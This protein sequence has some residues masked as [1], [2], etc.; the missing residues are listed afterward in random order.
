MLYYAIYRYIC[1]LYTVGTKYCHAKLKDSWLALLLIIVHSL[2]Q[3]KHA[4]LREWTHGKK[5]G[6]PSYWYRSIYLYLCS[7]VQYGHTNVTTA[8][9][10]V[11]KDSENCILKRLHSHK[12]KKASFFFC[13]QNVNEIENRSDKTFWVGVKSMILF[14]PCISGIN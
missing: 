9:D 6:Q 2:D 11:R 7:T 10:Q 14:H 5:E 12:K 1:I 8:F 4:V 13:S 3:V